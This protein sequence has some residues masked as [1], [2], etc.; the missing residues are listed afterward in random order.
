MMTFYWHMQ[1]ANR[2]IGYI[3]GCLVSSGAVTVED[4]KKVN[5]GPEKRKEN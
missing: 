1:Q 2:W 5:M 4:M 3:Q